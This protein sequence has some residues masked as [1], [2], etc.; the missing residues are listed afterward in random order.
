[1]LA[2]FSADDRDQQHPD[3]RVDGQQ[4]ADLE[5]RR[6]FDG[7][8]HEQQRG[9]GQREVLVAGAAADE[10]ALEPR[11]SMRG[12]LAGVAAGHAGWYE[13][14]DKPIA[15]SRVLLLA[16]L[17]V[18]A[19]GRARRGRPRRRGSR[20]PPGSPRAA[21]A[22]FDGYGDAETLVAGD[23]NGDGKADLALGS[24]QDEAVWLAFGTH[25]GSLAIQQSRVPGRRRAV[26][27]RGR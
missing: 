4:R 14:A 5:D 20:S 18:A 27:D 17:A 21:P 2:T 23:L 13:A 16:A 11:A 9:D 19:R 8:Q 25:S 22:G 15:A 1:M 7:E 6:S 24:F 26:R 12:T 3:E 10:Q